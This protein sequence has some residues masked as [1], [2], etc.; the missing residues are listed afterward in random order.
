MWALNCY[1]PIALQALHC[2]I[3]NTLS[4]SLATLRYTLLAII[5]AALRACCHFDAAVGQAASAPLEST[6]DEISN[7]VAVVRYVVF[8]LV[9]VDA[10][11]NLLKFEFQIIFMPTTHLPSR[12][13]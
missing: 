3:A 11:L 10:N 4:M 7:E 6:S 2:C 8:S 5:A 13:P 9:I 1:Y 12:W